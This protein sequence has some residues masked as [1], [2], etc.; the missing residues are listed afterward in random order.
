MRGRLDWFPLYA[1]KFLNSR[2]VRRMTDGQVGSYILL[3][4]EQW[5]G[6]PLQNDPAELARIGKTNQKKAMTVVEM[7]FKLTAKGWVNRR[8]NEVLREQTKKKTKASRDAKKAA[9][10]RWEKER[11]KR[12]ADA[13]QSHS[14]RM[15]IRTE[16]NR[17]EE[18]R[19][20]T[21]TTSDE[22]FEDFWEIYPKRAGGNRRKKQSPAGEVL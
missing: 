8:L 19:E 10:A 18:N 3:L 6:G 4:C 17:T 11:K 13:M 1:G 15:P 5:E 7:C 2:K 16:E 12:H 20:E 22:G 21:T 14:G 9:D